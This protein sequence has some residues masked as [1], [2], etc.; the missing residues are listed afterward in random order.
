MKKTSGGTV[1]LYHSLKGC[2]AVVGYLNTNLKVTETLVFDKV[3][4]NPDLY[5]FSSEL[6]CIL[7]FY[8]KFTDATFAPGVIL[9]TDSTSCTVGGVSGGSTLT[10]SIQSGYINNE[11]RLVGKVA[12]KLLRPNPLYSRI[13]LTFT[14]STSSKT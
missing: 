14:S 4:N 10:G 13:Y 7:T 8:K 3:I 6:K 9:A 11:S 12:F 1:G 2:G 5:Y